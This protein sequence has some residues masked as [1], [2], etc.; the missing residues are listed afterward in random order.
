M[1]HTGYR[2]SRDALVVERMRAAPTAGRITGA[3]LFMGRTVAVVAS[4]SWLLF[5][6]LMYAG[7]Q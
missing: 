3:A 4:L 6:A 7:A 5:V 2:G 1:A